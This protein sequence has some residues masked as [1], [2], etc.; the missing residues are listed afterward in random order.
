VTAR[1]ARIGVGTLGALSIAAF[2]ALSL[3]RLFCPIELGNGEGMM[4]DNAIRVARGQ[5]LYVAPSLDFIPF[6]Y[7]P[8]FSYL[9]APL[10][11]IFGPELWEGRLVD[12]LGVAGFV[13]VLMVIVRRETRSWALALAGA[14]LFL[15]GHGLTRG[16]YDV[17]RPDPLMLMLAFAGLAV[18]RFTTTARGA[19]V[20][21]LIAALG[22]FDKQHGILFG[23]AAIPWLALQDRRRFLPY[24]ATFLG[25][26]IGGYALLALWLGPW[27]P[28]YTWDVPS[29]W[30]QF[31]RGRVFQYFGDVLLGKLGPLVIPSALAFGV[32]GDEGRR[33]ES[34]WAWAAAAGIG[35]GLMATLDPYA[36]YHTLMPTIAAFCVLGPIALDRLARRLD[37]GAPARAAAAACVMLALQFLPLLYPMRT[38]IPRPGAAATRREFV[39][40]LRSL[41]GRVLMPYHGFYLTVAG[42]SMGMSVL[43]LDDVVRAKGNRLLRRDPQYFERL[44]DALRH[45]PG[46]PLIVNDSVFAKT[47]DASTSMWATL[48]QSYRRAGDLGDLIERLRPLAGSRNAPT[49][50]YAPVDSAAAAAPSGPL[51]APARPARPGRR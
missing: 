48:D 2:V 37:G 50:I 23:L 34:L 3:V 33:P 31:S 26:S 51:V 4:L 28:F 6:V 1:L 9:M 39:A 30:S 36:Y 11:K 12:L 5:P 29:H 20:A 14:G 27:F 38:L 47:G 10:V 46:R 7:M 40:K 13:I 22:F 32:G 35:T 45:G 19:V 21:A 15:M 24:T 41:P 8:M 42:K 49:W 25:A 43:P 44:F 16:G 18:L 17:V